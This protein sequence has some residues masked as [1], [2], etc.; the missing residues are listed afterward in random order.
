MLEVAFFVLN[1]I[2][3][4]RP[5]FHAD[6]TSKITSTHQLL[7]TRFVGVTRVSDKVIETCRWDV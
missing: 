2:S 4:V 7:P 3:G 5:F 6:A 1:S